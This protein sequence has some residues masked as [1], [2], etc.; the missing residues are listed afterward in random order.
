MLGLFGK[1]LDSN[2]KE[3]NKLKKT[4]EEVNSLGKKVS[5]LTD[6]Q[7][8][9][10]FAEFKLKNERGQ[11]SWKNIKREDKRSNRNV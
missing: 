11:S 2:D 6:R 9:A 3:I 7:L 8:Q 10:K 4:I 5:K 1:L